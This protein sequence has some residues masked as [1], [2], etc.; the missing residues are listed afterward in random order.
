M[1]K[2]ED[3][4]AEADYD[5]ESIN[6]VNGSNMTASERRS[7]ASQRNRAQYK[8]Y[9][10]RMTSKWC[11]TCP[12]DL[13]FNTYSKDIHN[14]KFGLQAECKACKTKRRKDAR[15]AKQAK[16]SK[17]SDRRQ[18]GVPTKREKQEKVN[19][20]AMP[21]VADDAA[22]SFVPRD[23]HDFVT[24]TLSEAITG[25]GPSCANDGQ[26]PVIYSGKRTLGKFS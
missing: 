9:G 12:A 11:N 3:D 8:R 21:T 1:V 20:A 10:E 18:G 16:E 22:K 2:E 15:S 7:E 4:D 5:D 13:A 6:V 25:V 17:G 19:E 26:E 23:L 24:S 14:K